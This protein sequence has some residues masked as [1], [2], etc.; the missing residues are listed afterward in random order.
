MGA[1]IPPEHRG[2]IFDRFIR[3]GD[4]VERRRGTGLGLAFCKMAIEAHGG[5]IWVEDP[6]EGKGSQFCF[7]LPVAAMLPPFS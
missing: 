4:G 1:G 2:R 7:S 5:S 3:L 6:P